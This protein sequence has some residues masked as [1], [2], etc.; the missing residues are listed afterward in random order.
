MEG[1]TY[2]NEFFGVKFVAPNGYTYYDDAK[3]AELNAAV[4]A[5]LTDETLVKALENG[6]AYF[7]MACASA[8]GSNVNA[9][10]EHGGITG[11]SALT[12][13]QY[14]ATAKESLVAQLKG[15][16][17]EVKSI[18]TTT[19]KSADGKD[20]A[21]MKLQLDVQ[22]TTLYEQVVCL[23]AG[24]YF[25]NITATSPNEADLETLLN[26]VSAL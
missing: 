3:M 4:G 2:T 6:V 13:E 19:F 11:A 7:D 1:N 8:S 18:D 25:M 26:G 9:T 16:G 23:K 24:D 22:G 14:I 21:S 17:A 10:I 20:L 5:T 12:P 15:S